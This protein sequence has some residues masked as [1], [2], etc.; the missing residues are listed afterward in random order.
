MTITG[1][2]HRPHP[3]PPE[4]AWTRYDH[5]IRCEP[6]SDGRRDPDDDRIGSYAARPT[7]HGLTDDEIEAEIKRLTDALGWPRSEA[8]LAVSGNR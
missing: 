8:Q 7:W 4:S 5:A 2:R 3:L 6:L 1:P